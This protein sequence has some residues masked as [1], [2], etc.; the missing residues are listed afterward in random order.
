[1]KKLFIYFLSICILNLQFA[2]INSYAQDYD[3]EEI[4]NRAEREINLEDAESASPEDISA[5]YQGVQ[6]FTLIFIVSTS[7][8]TSIM[9]LLSCVNTLDTKVFMGGS[10]YYVFNEISN[11]VKFT[12]AKKLSKQRLTAITN[13]TEEKKS[14]QIEAI[15]ETEAT[16]QA[17]LEAVKS[18]IKSTTIAAIAW[19][20]AAVLALA[21]GICANGACLAGSAAAKPF[22]ACI[23]YIAPPFDNKNLISDKDKP[24][25]KL[26]E[27]AKTCNNNQKE[28]KNKDKL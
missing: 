27:I 9:Y 1:M 8:V 22:D 2:T 16:Y 7:I 19:A 11:F 20:A 14:R 6:W 15:T 3:Q 5:M 28:S 21:I 12:K 17:A 23:I 13:T 26:K 4:E 24:P 25:T 10:A 18:R